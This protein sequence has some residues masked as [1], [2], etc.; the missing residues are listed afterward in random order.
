M[1]YK[2]RILLIFCVLSFSSMAQ[3]KILNANFKDC[4]AR[5]ENNKLVVGNSK[6]E[7]TWH[8]TGKGFLTSSLLNKISGKEWCNVK[9]TIDSDWQLPSVG[10]I[11]PEGKILKLE[12][13]ENNDEKFS[14]MHLQVVA[15]VEYPSLKTTVK[16]EIWIF[17]TTSGLR[18]QLFVKSKQSFAEKSESTGIPATEMLVV[19][20]TEHDTLV[21]AVQNVI[22]NNLETFYRT[23]S[24]INLN[25]PFNYVVID[26]GRERNVESV[27]LN[28]IQDYRKLGYVNKC[29][30]YASNNPNQWD[31]PPI[32]VAELNRSD[33]LQYITCTPTKARYIRVTA[34]PTSAV[35][36]HDYKSSIA[37]IRIFDSEHPV[38]QTEELVVEYLPVNANGLVRRGMGYYGDTQWRNSLEYPFIREESKQSSF[39]KELW[40]WNNILSIE[41]KNE[42]FCL[43]K[44]SHKTVLQNGHYTGGFVCTAN[45]ISTTGWGIGPNEITEEYKKCWA[46]WTILYQGQ[47]DERQLAIK[48]FDRKR[49]PNTLPGH[50]QIYACSWG[51][52]HH[53][54]RGAKDG[55][56][57]S[58]VLAELDASKSAGIEAYLIDDGWQVHPDTMA[59]K[60]ENGIWHP[61]SVTYPNGWKTVI[62]KARANNI[63]LALWAS[64]DIPAA[65]LNYNQKIANFAGWKW[66]FAFIDS[67]SELAKIEEKARNF[68]KSYNHQLSIQWDLTE[69]MPRYGFYWGREYGIVWL[70][71]KETDTRS[72]V[73]WTRAHVR[74]NP[75]Q[76]LRDVWELSK[77]VNTD[78]FQLPIRNLNDFN[79]AGNGMLYN[80]EYC[81]AI[82]FMG[83]PMFFEEVGSY[84][85]ES[86]ARIKKNLEMYKKTRGQLKN[87]IVFP[88]G[89]QPNNESYTGFQ[90]VNED[91]KT[92]HLLVFRELYAT[93]PSHEIKLRF[94]RNVTLEL[95]NLKTGN[96]QQLQVDEYG[97]AVFAITNAADFEYYR[98]KILK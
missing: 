6:M 21:N 62:E 50:Y 41:D 24:A 70:A 80:I 58:N 7:R 61:H 69:N 87:S 98:Y 53:P 14:A 10:Y 77:Y 79:K 45:G 26:L 93:E 8:W 74:Y 20:A 32:G 78:K 49:F 44:E 13:K 73:S 28:Q 67:N 92:G 85:K 36:L 75:P 39:N 12:A 23:N 83:N 4:Y 76:V 19:K 18:T 2:L 30:V 43:I 96:L 91:G 81:N 16:F 38:R 34:L 55:A 84:N 52:S 40:D 1:K 68:I 86:L 66:D 94:L 17:P 9:P 15:E 64:V 71:N 47:D 5:F 89:E 59:W 97:I 29:A 72:S 42:G 22:D 11:L 27:G 60:P 57:E 88:I 90:A 37:E 25:T 63:Q 65:D 48:T 56:L 51:N 95:E 33:Y 3:K 54:K 46:N 31:T 82:T 35:N